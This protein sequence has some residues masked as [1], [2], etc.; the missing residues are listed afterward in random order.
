[1]KER[2]VFLFLVATI[3]LTSLFLFS[4]IGYANV[5]LAEYNNS[6]SSQESSITF[7]KNS[8]YIRN[9]NIISPQK[10]SLNNITLS[11]LGEIQKFTIPV[12]NTNKNAAAKLQT[13]IFNSNT[14]YFKVTCN[15]SKSVL[16]EQSDEA[17]IE[18]SVQLIKTPIHSA[19]TAEITINITSE[20]IY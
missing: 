12:I 6:C 4:N 20:H 2:N 3:V 13:S 19:E 11:E 8:K 10:A 14:E 9:V 5:D 18:I 1:M 15:S 17:I 16:N 7:S